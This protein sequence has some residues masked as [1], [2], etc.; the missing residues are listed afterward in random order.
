MRRWTIA[1]GLLSMAAL[2]TVFTENH[3][4][5]EARTTEYAQDKM[6]QLLALVYTDGITDT[7]T[8]PA[9]ATGGTG[10]AFWRRD[11]K[12][13]YYLG[14][15]QAVM[16]VEVNTTTPTFT[17]GRPRILF[18]LAEGTPVTATMANVSRDGERVLIAVPP[19][20]LVQMTVFDRQ[21]QIVG[22]VGEPGSYVMPSFSPDGTRVAVL[23]ND[24][25]TGNRDVWTFEADE[26]D[27]DLEESVYL[28]GRDG[29]RRTVQIVVHGEARQISRLSWSFVQVDP[30]EVASHNRMHEEP[31]LPL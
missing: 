24:R 20:Q 1:V 8:F 29:P 4:H 10:M 21:G 30:A 7:T 13:L 27:V 17:F 11:G 15:N 22:R 31:E 2:A 9:T 6:E 12:E 28:A 23:R 18:R 25:E 26:G 16:V 19:P 14:A 5:L 3:G